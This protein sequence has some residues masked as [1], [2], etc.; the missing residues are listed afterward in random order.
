MNKK[1]IFR[2]LGFIMIV[3]AALMLLPVITAFCFGESDWIYFA[4]TIA[5]TVIVG[6][7]LLLV[8]RKGKK[9]IHAMDGFVTVALA[10]IVLSAIAAVPFVISGYIPDFLN[11]MFETVSGFST[12][13][14]SAMDDVEILSNCMQFWREFTNWIGGMGILVFMLAISPV[15]GGG[16]AI[17]MLRA[18]SPGPVTEKISPK[19][20]NTAKYLYG[21]YLFFT[22]AEVVSLMIAGLSF[23][24]ALLT[25]FGTMATGGFSYLNTSLAGFT[26]A[27]QTI[28]TIFMVIAGVNFSLFFLV[29][30]GKVKDALKNEEFWTYIGIY[31]T[32]C[33]LLTVS[34]CMNNNFD[35]VGDAVHNVAFSVASVITTT[36]Y[37]CCDM[38]VWTAFAKH[39]CMFLM[40]FGACAGSTAGGMKISRL[41]IGFKTIRRGLKKL[42]HPR[43]VYSV[44]YNGKEVS[45]SVTGEIM[46]FLIL[47]IAIFAGS[48]IIVTIDPKADFSTAF[49]AVTTTLNNN[50]ISFDG[51]FG[52]F[53][54]YAWYSKVVFIIDMLVGRLEIFPIIILF[55][56]ILYPVKSAGRQF[57]KRVK[58][59]LKKES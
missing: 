24:H 16:S 44:R 47:Y 13:G 23:F 28:V 2:I 59:N 56:S 9:N 7:I 3:E 53:S 38:N 21:I 50:G 11:A 41:G 22:L 25:A 30:I 48:M 34:V 15:A 39:L 58:W 35:S 1:A 57:V 40:F 46:F 10:W 12:T 42:M 4:I 5:G 49:S 31:V 32:A 19:I 54:G 20:S 27:Q 17:H 33:V 14:A 6:G 8:T 36:G 43:G 55:N 29:I 45:E 26:Y 18:E 37:C 51:A 52:S